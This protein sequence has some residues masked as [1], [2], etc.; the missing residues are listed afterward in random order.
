MSFW[1]RWLLQIQPWSVDLVCVNGTFF[2][3]GNFHTWDSL[4]GMM[5]DK[6]N[7]LTKPTVTVVNIPTFILLWMKFMKMW[8]CTYTVNKLLVCPSQPCFCLRTIQYAVYLTRSILKKKNLCCFK[9]SK[10]R[11]MSFERQIT[12]VLWLD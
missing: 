12:V 11:H 3:F 6:S 1:T 2:F 8:Y 7:S 9:C 4:L 10:L 5:L